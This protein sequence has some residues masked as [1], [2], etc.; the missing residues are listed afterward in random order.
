MT[1]PHDY[2]TRAVA[3]DCTQQARRIMSHAVK[4]D[5]DTISELLEETSQR[6]GGFGLYALCCAFAETIR[7]ICYPDVPRGLIN[8]TG[9]MMMIIPLQDNVE[10]DHPDIMWAAR[11][12][13]AYINGD[14]DT[15]A[16][17]FANELEAA[18]EDEDTGMAGMAALISQVGHVY[19]EGA[20]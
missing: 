14:A 1:D 9:G 16:A 5:A 3:E 6:W 18:H 10:R 7:S 19:K 4:Q 15:C 17:L 8:G 20:M 2:D 11:F 12:V 13:T